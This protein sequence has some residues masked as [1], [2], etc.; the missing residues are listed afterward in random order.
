MSE[1]LNRREFVIK[2]SAVKMLGINAKLAWKQIGNDIIIQM[3]DE[4]PCEY[5]YSFKIQLNK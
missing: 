5:A 4:K 3:P 1:N 2:G